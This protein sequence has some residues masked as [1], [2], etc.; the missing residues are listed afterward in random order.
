MIAAL[1]PASLWWAGLLAWTPLLIVACSTTPVRAGLT[2]WLQGIVAQGW[3]LASVMHAMTK[4]GGASTITATLVGLV[5]D[6]SEGARVG[7]V[8]WLTA[9]LLRKSWPITWVFPVALMSFEFAYPMVFPW[10]TPRMT[11]VIACAPFC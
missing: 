8:A 7:L 6:A 9:H 3:A 10:T 5:L 4:T 11:L 1:P 2:G